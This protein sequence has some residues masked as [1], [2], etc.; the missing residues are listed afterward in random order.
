MIHKLEQMIQQKHMLLHPFYQAWT[1][2]MLQ[3]ETLQTYAKEYYHHV[4]AF[5]T[6]LSALHSRCE[7]PKIRKSLL[8]NLIDE[9]A[10]DPNH[11][12]LWRSFTLALGV[13]EEELGAHEPSEATLQMIQ[14][15]RSSCNTGPLAIGVAALYSYESQ[16]PAI[17]QTKIEGLKK[18]Y[19]LTDPAGYRYFSVH[20][21]ADVEHSQTE[22]EMLEALMRP[23]EEEAVLKGAEK[24]LDSLGNFLSSFL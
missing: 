17:C 10:G 8:T 6:Y 15:F 4:K 5:P 3:K 19:G 18:W 11:P 22:K 20:E 14:Q 23:E 12:D 24:T 9:E 7:D 13:K 16:I 2:G 21:V 1:C